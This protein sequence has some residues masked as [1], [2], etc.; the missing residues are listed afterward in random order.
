MSD[1]AFF[2]M[3]KKKCIEVE[4]TVASVLQNVEKPHEKCIP[5]NL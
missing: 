2:P 5:A 4:V 1:K 3:T